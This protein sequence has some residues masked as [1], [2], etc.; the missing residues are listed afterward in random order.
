MNEK[1]KDHVND[2]LKDAPRTR[3]IVDLQEELLSGCLDKYADLTASGINAEE[4]YEE[5]IS[6]IGDVNE[7]IGAERKFTDDKRLLG[8]L[9]SSLW[10]LVTL[11]YLCFGFLFS[12]WHPGWLIFILGAVL[13][14]LLTAA[15]VDTG[16]RKA[17][18]TGALYTSA[19]FVFLIFGFATNQWHIA[20]LTFMLAVAIQQIA[21]LIRVWRDDK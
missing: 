6:G 15:F 21:R 7:L 12:W 9:S 1:I 13:Q 18:L 19:T 16:K 11:C 17:A 3:R 4:A 10:S 5:V 14:N 2:L 20:C 8:P